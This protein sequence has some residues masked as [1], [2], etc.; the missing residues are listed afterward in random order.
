MKNLKSVAVVEQQNSEAI[1]NPN[2]EFVVID[3]ETTGL[4]KNDRVIEIGC[5]VFSGEKMLEEWSTLVN[6]SRDLG[7]THIHKITPSMVSIA[8]TFEEISNDLLRLLN[9]RIIVGHNASFDIR[10]LKQEFSRLGVEVDFGKPFCTMVGARQLLPLGADSLIDACRYSGLI[11]EGAHSALGD[12]R[13]TMSLFQ[14][15]SLSEQESTPAKCH[16]SPDLNPHPTVPRKIFERKSDDAIARIRAFTKKVPFPTADQ[17]EV[18][19]LLL[20]NMAMDDLVISPEENVELEQWAEELGISKNRLRELH[21]GYL[22]SFVQA[23]LRDGIVS[24]VEKEILSKISFALD[25]ELVIPD[26]PFTISSEEPALRPGNKICFTGTAISPSGKQIFR[27]DLEAMAARVGLNP[28]SS[29]TKNGCDILVAAD[30]VSMS[31]KAQKARDWGIL[32]ISVDKFI[33]LCTFG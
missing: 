26:S 2:L 3:T 6:P 28:V 24:E 13:M 32:V 16:Y 12:A 9:G 20:L 33:T 14:V 1:V 7:P 27:A 30:E 19:Y 25:I 15:V 17:K 21:V 5:V 8:P 29:V 11:V 10:M 18:A 4:F 22:D 23:A 31:G